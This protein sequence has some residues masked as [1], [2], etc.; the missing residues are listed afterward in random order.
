MI[1]II[2]I[3]S[4]FCLLVCPHPAHLL[5]IYHQICRLGLFTMMLKPIR[6]QGLSMLGKYGFDTGFGSKRLLL[7]ISLDIEILL[8]GALVI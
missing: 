4:F 3:Y 2:T 8:K 7:F 5:F 1:D 6:L